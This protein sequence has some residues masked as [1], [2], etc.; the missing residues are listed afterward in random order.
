MALSS[1]QMPKKSS[2][3]PADRHSLR[4]PAAAIWLGAEAEAEGQDSAPKRDTHVPTLNKGILSADGNS[5]CFHSSWAG[6][7]STERMS[8]PAG[9]G[10]ET[11]VGFPTGFG[12]RLGRPAPWRR[13]DRR[14]SATPTRRLSFAGPVRSRCRPAGVCANLS[15]AQSWFSF[16]VCDRRT[17]TPLLPLGWGGCPLVV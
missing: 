2:K 16:K 14:P 17:D 11:G 6:A 7:V 12:G 15:F 5:E 13:I 4:F 8:S 10:M 1:L 3:G 9:P